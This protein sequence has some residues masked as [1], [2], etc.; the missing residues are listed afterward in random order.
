VLKPRRPG[1]DVLDRIAMTRPGDG[2]DHDMA[3]RAESPTL[4]VAPGQV[5]AGAA[6]DRLVRRD[7][8]LLRLEAA[9]GRRTAMAA[10]VVGSRRQARSVSRPS[11]R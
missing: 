6:L 9:R 10:R 11:G 8:L 7:L 2:R 5:R 3:E 1:S 4:S